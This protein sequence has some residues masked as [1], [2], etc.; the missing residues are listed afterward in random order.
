MHVPK[1]LNSGLVESL[2]RST[3]SPDEYDSYVALAENEAQRKVWNSE[4]AVSYK[5]HP[6]PMPWWLLGLEC[7]LTCHY[8]AKSI[9]P[10]DTLSVKGRL[11]ASLPR[12]S[13]A[14][15]LSTKPV[16]QAI[17]MLFGMFTP[18]GGYSNTLFD[19]NTEAVIM[20]V[21]G[22]CYQPRTEP[23]LLTSSTNTHLTHRSRGHWYLKRPGTARKG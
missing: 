15:A 3:F 6:S 2:L 9:A 22:K 13:H 14:E 18:W 21:V 16:W 5:G 20:K 1:S 23:C 12:P 11:R 8:K 10:G 4:A 17:Y 7:F 19:C